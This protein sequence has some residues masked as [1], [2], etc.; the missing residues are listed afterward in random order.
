MIRAARGRSMDE[1]MDG[2]DLIICL[3][4]WMVYKRRL[5]LICDD[6]LA[7]CIASR[8]KL[9]FTSL[10]EPILEAFRGP[11]GSQNR[12]LGSFFSMLFL[13]AISASIFVRFGEAAT[14]KNH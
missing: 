2:V 6:L 4:F 1:W 5:P 12:L 13:N 3:A 7:S 11:N 8:N 9:R 10:F 14:S